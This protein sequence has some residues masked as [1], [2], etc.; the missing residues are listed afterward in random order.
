M[1][2]WNRSTPGGQVFQD[3]SGFR[4]VRVKRLITLLVFALAGL[5]VWLMPTALAWNRTASPTADSI[6]DALP[7]RLPLIGSGTL[8]RVVQVR[9]IGSDPYAA[10]P[11]TGRPW[12]RLSRA[13]MQQVGWNSYAIEQFGTPRQRQLALTFDDGPDP[14]NTPPLLDLLSRYHVPATFFDIGENVMAHPDLYRREVREGHLVGNH[15]YTHPQLSSHGSSRDH[16]QLVTTSRLMRGLDGPA[17]R[18]FRPPYGGDDA[19]SIEAAGAAILEAQQDG[20]A[21]ATFDVDTNDWQYGPHRTIPVPPLDGAGHVLLMHD[22]G[23][24]RTD[25]LVLVEK[26]IRSA[27]AKGYTFTT[28]DALASAPVRGQARS[29]PA[30][31][32]RVTYWALWAVRELPGAVLQFL[33]VLGVG[34]MILVTSGNVVLALIVR[35]RDSRR[36]PPD[37]QPFVTVLIAAYNEA[38]VIEK[39]LLAVR[40][41]R[42][43]ALE[44]IVVDDGSTDGTVEI[45]HRIAGTWPAL[46]VIEARHGGKAAALNR[47]LTAARAEVV[48]TFDADTVVLPDTVGNLA[49]HFADERLGA[50]AGLVKVGNRRGLLARWQSL[51]YISG[52]TVERMAQ[53]LLG[54][55]MI[56]PGACAA[57]RR[58]AVLSV[59]GYSTDTLAEDCD[60]T[61]KLQHAGWRIGQDIDAMALTEAPTKPRALVRQRSRWMFGNLQAIW[62]HRT[63]LG[64]SRYGVLG[65]LVMPYAVVSNQLPLVFLPFVYLILVRA[66]LIGHDA[67]VWLYLG[68]LTAFQFVVALC[69]VLMARERLWHLLIVPIY[70][71]IYEPLRTYLLYASAIAILRGRPVGWSKVPRANSVRLP[72]AKA[73]APAASVS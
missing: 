49:R 62:K 22:G 53:S 24:D 14:R 8:L 46:R 50:L 66:L 72:E 30:L 44:A 68:G 57:W 1:R 16:L 15:T 11:F 59:G 12:R 13:E 5:T 21:T 4:W 70:R 37:H 42:Y 48:V 23:G 54:A 10:D 36:A 65:L 73:A 19:D 55:V 51:E 3:H 34:T 25:T 40:A 56:V 58:S 35:R 9:W 71:L 38:A 6:A 52:I 39:T 32:D 29:A 28:L 64:R 33:F 27:K 26:L 47:G 60:L 20:M 45:L 41:S 67:P 7:A 43:P 2:R 17:V 69:A 63:M 31:I 61:L 18:Y